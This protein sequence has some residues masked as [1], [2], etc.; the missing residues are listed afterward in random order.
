MAKTVKSEHKKGKV[1]TELAKRDVL[2]LN[3]QESNELTRECI[4]MALI[5][6]MSEKPFE[7]ISISEITKRAGVSRTAFYRNYTSKEDVIRE[8]GKYVIDQLV[9]ILS[10]I[11]TADDV[12]D[13]L[14]EFFEKIKEHKEQIELLVKGDVSLKLLFPNAHILENVIPSTSQAEHYR[15]VAIDSALVGVVREWINNSCDLSPEE[16]ARIIELGA[17]YY[18]DKK[19]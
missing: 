11:K 3:N 13:R 15:M 17:S 7:S 12:H 8:I 5:Y 14:V 10:N 1:Q 9:S 2:R 6:L 19:G 18:S 16:M 4:D